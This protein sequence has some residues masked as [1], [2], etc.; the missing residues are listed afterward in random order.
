MVNVRHVM[1]LPL[2]NKNIYSKK[3]SMKKGFK[4][5]SMLLKRFSTY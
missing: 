1:L 5:I 3:K 4:N 2:K